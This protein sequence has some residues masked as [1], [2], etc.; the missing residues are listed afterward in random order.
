MG[1]ADLGFV[2]GSEIEAYAKRNEAQ[3]KVDNRVS[4]ILLDESRQPDPNF[5]AKDRAGFVKDELESAMKAVDGRRMQ[6]SKER[7]AKELSKLTP[8]EFRAVID[9]MPQ[10][11]EGVKFPHLM[12]VEDKGN[13]FFKIGPDGKQFAGVN[14]LAIPELKWNSKNEAAQLKTQICSPDNA[15]QKRAQEKIASFTPSQIVS[16]MGQYDLKCEK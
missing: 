8:S 16:I 14:W 13:L 3:G 5:N 6:L 15:E 12:A 1:A 11:R 10:P 4:T 2:I 7:I 9:E